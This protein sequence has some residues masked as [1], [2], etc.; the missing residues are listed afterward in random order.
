MDREQLEREIRG[1]LVSIKEGLA[2]L[3][4]LIRVNGNAVKHS[5]LSD[6]NDALMKSD[7]LIWYILRES[8][9]Q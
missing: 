6:I 8:R 9:K 7:K 2:G 4:D 3:D 5:D 1:K